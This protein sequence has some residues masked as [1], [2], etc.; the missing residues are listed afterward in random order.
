MDVKI[1]KLPKIYGFNTFSEAGP[2]NFSPSIFLGG[3]N[4][5]CAYCMNAKI[6]LDY[7]NLKEIDI[8]QVKDF[9]LKN[10]CEYVNI[11]GGEAT[12][13][14]A[15]ELINL[16]DEIKSWGVKASLSTN[17][18]KPYILKSILNNLNY[19]TMDIKTSESKYKD[20]YW[21]PIDHRISFDYILL[22]LKFLREEKS[23]RLDF[24]FEIRT[25]LYK[26]IVSIDDLKNIGKYLDKNDKWVLQPFRKSKEM[27]DKNAY[28]SL[29]YNIDDFKIMKEC[30][31]K[32]CDN[33]ILRDV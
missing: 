31:K 24:D 20:L 6:V 11:S 10:K 4:L 14:H 12:N 8:N 7:N 25:T 23:N 27:I 9:V 19:V 28:D 5:R 30:C 2:D 1:E 26:P 13:R 33:V 18:L 15:Y 29:N 16:L 22:S 17:G 3:C 32:Y 21:Y